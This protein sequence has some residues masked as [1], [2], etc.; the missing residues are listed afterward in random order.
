MNK[1]VKYK[2]CPLVEVIFQLRFPTILSIN[3]KQPAEFQEKIRRD[4]PYYDEGIEEQNELLLNANGKAAQ[5]KTN[6]NKNYSFISIDET[7]KVNLTSTFIAIS[8]RKYTQWEEFSVKV[9]Q[10]VKAFQE[11]YEVPFYTRIGLRY[12]DVI[13]R[14]VLNLTS[15][16]WSDLIKPHVLGIVTQFEDG[17]NSYMSQAEFKDAADGVWTKTHFEL[18][19]VNNNTEDSLLIDCDYFKPETTKTDMMMDVAN[20]LHEHSSSFLMTAITEKL[21]KAMESEELV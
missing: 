21:D 8:T 12:I 18:V 9:E 10:V 19:N 17:M 1:R 3:T 5:V 4:Y 7:Y 13:Q 20:M 16:K 2:N 15:E 14:S 11:V 6:Q